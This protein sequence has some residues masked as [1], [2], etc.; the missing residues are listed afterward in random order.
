MN[1]IDTKTGKVQSPGN[2]LKLKA[3]SGFPGF[4]NK[5]P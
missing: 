1:N 2:F 3:L 4:L 5:I